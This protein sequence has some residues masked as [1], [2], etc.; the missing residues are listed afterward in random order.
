LRSRT[1]SAAR[2]S[3]SGFTKSILA[4]TTEGLKKRICR[5]HRAAEPLRA[6]PAF[7][8]NRKIIEPNLLFG[9]PE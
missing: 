6:C 3:F 1:P 8:Y 2:F 4:T 9:Y 7:C 5:R